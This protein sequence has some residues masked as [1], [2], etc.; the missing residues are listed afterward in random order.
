LED[1]KMRKTILV[2]F[3]LIVAFVMGLFVGCVNAPSSNK[4][5]SGLTVSHI[6]NNVITTIQYDGVYILSYGGGFVIEYLRFYENGIVIDVA[7]TGR[8]EEIKEWFNSDNMD[9]GMGKY[10]IDGEKISFSTKSPEGSIDYMGD[11]TTNGLVLSSHS[12]INGYEEQNL[13][14]M[15]YKW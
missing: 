4:N 12:N 3:N 13:K 6:E 1:E 11:I 14:Y 8:P 9:I 15:F 2:L 7:S 10:K 5:E